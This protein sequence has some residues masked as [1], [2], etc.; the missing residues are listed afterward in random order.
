MEVYARYSGEKVMLT[1]LSLD[2]ESV[3]KYY[4]WMNEEE[5]LPWLGRQTQVTTLEWE[6][7]WAK[8]RAEQK[9]GEAY[10][11][12][13]TKEDKVLIGTCR[14]KIAGKCNAN[15]GICIGSKEHRDSGYGTEAM[16]L[17]AK[18]AF[19]EWGVHRCTLSLADNNPRALRCYTKVGFKEWGREHE[20]VFYGGKWHDCIH[21]EMLSSDWFGKE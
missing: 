7:E 10:F 2:E 19:E 12:I 6:R 11:S 15:L 14:M 17:L 9:D 5:I 4:Q 20:V 3:L 13:Y 16:T 8:Q 1:A 21:M 18:F